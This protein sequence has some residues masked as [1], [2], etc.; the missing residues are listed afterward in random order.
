M[1]ALKQQETLHVQRNTR[2]NS[3]WERVPSALSSWAEVSA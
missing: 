1:N 3:R 2:D